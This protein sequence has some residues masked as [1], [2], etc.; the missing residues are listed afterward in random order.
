[1]RRAAPVTGADLR[2]AHG[3]RHGGGWGRRAGAVFG[4]ALWLSWLATAIW[5]GGRLLPADRAGL[6]AVQLLAFTPYAAAGSVLVLA[7]A[8]AT[9]RWRLTGAALLTAAVLLACV[10]PRA[11]ADRGQVAAGPRL[12]VL[13]VNMWVGSADAATIV[14]L[15]RTHR[16]DVLALQELTTP[17][18]RALDAAGLARLLPYRVSYVEPQVSGLF[19]RFPLLDDGVRVLPSAFGQARATVSVPGTPPVAVESVHTYAPIGTRARDR[20][21]V[22]LAGQPPATVDGPVRLLLGDFN[23]TLDHAPLRRLL[24]TGYRDAGDIRGAGFAATWPDHGHVVLPVTIDHVLADRR[25][26]VVSYRVFPVRG[27]DHRAVYA[28]LALPAYPA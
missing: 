1:V 21:A 23:A 4:G 18:Q 11:V 28:E 3:G 25:V 14:G 10:V 20:W 16:V 2:W 22:D 26:G 5:A 6:L 19:S 17:G 8:S 13:T 9:R 24:A 15:V 7:A 27:T 12:R